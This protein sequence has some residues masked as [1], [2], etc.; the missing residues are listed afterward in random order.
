MLRRSRLWIEANPPD[1]LQALRAAM[2][3]ETTP[4]QSALITAWVNDRVMN[5]TH[6]LDQ[7]SV[8]ELA[9]LARLSPQLTRVIHYLA[10]GYEGHEV[11]EIMGIRLATVKTYRERALREARCQL[12]SGD[13]HVDN[14]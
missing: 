5:P 14:P 4:Q 7:P 3:D 12:E 13:P 11:A 9:C 6:R 2:H 10:A 1:L 8:E